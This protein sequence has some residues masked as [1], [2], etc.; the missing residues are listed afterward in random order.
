MTMV[1][2]SS[3]TP[4]TVNEKK[5]KPPPPASA[6]A[7]ETITLTGLPVRTSSEPGAAGEGQRH[8]HLRRRLADPPG[9]HDDHGQQ[10]GHRPVEADERREYGAEH[11]DGTHQPDVALAGLLDQG[12]AGPRGHAGGVDALAD[13]EQ[14]GDEDDDRVAEAGERLLEGEDACRPQ[15]EGGADGHDPDREPVPDEQDDHAQQDEQADR[16]VG[17][18]PTL[19]GDD[20][21]CRVRCP[22]R[23]GARPDA[24]RLLYAHRR[25]CRDAD[26]M[27]GGHGPTRLRSH[28]SGHAAPRRTRPERPRR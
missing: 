26:R 18:G 19:S 28:G 7:S 27:G 1:P 6:D 14:G 20:G 15:R 13:H 9:E 3:G 16:R 22:R 4:M 17:H 5:V 21:R 23:V 11:E 25:G 8:E 12:L 10:G 2:N 24:R